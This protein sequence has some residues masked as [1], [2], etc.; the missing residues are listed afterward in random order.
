MYSVI[1][2]QVSVCFEFFEGRNEKPDFF[3]TKSR[4]TKWKEIENAKSKKKK[5]PIQDLNPDLPIQ[6]QTTCPLHHHSSVVRD[7]KK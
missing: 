7:A 2:V 6:R 1:F 5:F 4:K 3:S